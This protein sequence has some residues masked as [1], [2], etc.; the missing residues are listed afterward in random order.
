MNQLMKTKDLDCI[1]NFGDMPIKTL[2]PKYAEAGTTGS[3]NANVGI[4]NFLCKKMMRFF[5]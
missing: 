3:N 1:I 2:T 5:K 4:K